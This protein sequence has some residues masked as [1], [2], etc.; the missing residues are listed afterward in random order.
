M[1]EFF[2]LFLLPARTFFK[3]YVQ[4]FDTVVEASG[5]ACELVAALAESPDVAR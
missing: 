5:R 2:E 3:L 4:T 1:N